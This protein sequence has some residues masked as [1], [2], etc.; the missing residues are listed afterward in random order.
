[1]LL[2]A[3]HHDRLAVEPRQAADDRAI[4]PER[5]VAMQL[6]EVREQRADVLERLGA[7]RM[8]RDHGHL[9]WRQLRVRVLQERFALLAQ[10]AEL[11]GDVY[12]GIVLDEPKRIDLLLEVSDRLF[13]V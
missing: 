3:D 12:G 1:P 13:E 4:V 6:V 5:P 9:P 2:V 10:P 8:A 11:L 7:L